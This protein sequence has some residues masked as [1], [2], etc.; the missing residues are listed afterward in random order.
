MRS[1]KQC[2]YII[3]GS[4]V[5]FLHKRLSFVSSVRFNAFSSL[6]PLVET[7]VCHVDLLCW[8]VGLCWF[9]RPRELSLPF[10][11][12]SQNLPGDRGP[13]RAVRMIGQQVLVLSKWDQ[14][15]PTWSFVP[16]NSWPVHGRCS[17][18][19]Q[20][21][22]CGRLASHWPGRARASSGVLTMLTVSI[23][24]ASLDNIKLS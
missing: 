11:R 5:G 9:S 13:A 24:S 10:P 22:V 4:L 17:G 21:P 18:P 1:H 23:V 19:L 7:P 15:V 2:Q 16:L 14:H 20:S 6:T 8:L 12:A 3:K